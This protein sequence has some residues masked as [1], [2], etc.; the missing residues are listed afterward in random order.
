MDKRINN[1]LGDFYETPAWAIES[2]CER[3]KFHKNIWEPSFGRGA[4]SRV[5]MKEGY[6]VKS[7]DL[8][9]Q[10][11]EKLDCNG[12]PIEY[13]ELDFLQ[14]YPDL[15]PS[16]DLV[17]RYDI[18]TNPPFNLMNDFIIQ[19]GKLC[20]DK[21]AFLGRMALLE[22]KYR[23]NNIYSQDLRC[24]LETVLV[25]TKRVNFVSPTITVK[26]SSNAMAMAWFVFKK[27]YKGHPKIDWF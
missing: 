16:N 11:G 10:G 13:Q 20:N 12:K 19:A 21:F 22:G 5:L 23:Y 25:A 27:D 15:F 2:L 26:S 8:H 9:D 24:N 7:T 14:C 4:I 3:V 1:P 18:I 6:N 17:G